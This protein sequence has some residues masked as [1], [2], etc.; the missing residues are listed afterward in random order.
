VAN[1]TLELVSGYYLRTIN[2]ETA[3]RLGDDIRMPVI[4]TATASC[5]K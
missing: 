4:S 1:I 3:C 2:F 5:W